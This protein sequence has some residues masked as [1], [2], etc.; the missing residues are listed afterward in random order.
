MEVYE[1][2]DIGVCEKCGS[3][4]YW[5]WQKLVSERPKPGCECQTH[6]T[7]EKLDEEINNE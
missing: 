4:M 1:Q 2:I 7:P 3:R 6:F 5:Q